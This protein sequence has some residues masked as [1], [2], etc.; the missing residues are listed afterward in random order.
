METGLYQF[1]CAKWRF[2]VNNHLNLNLS[3]TLLFYASRR[4]REHEVLWC[5]FFS[6]WTA[7]WY[8][9]AEQVGQSKN[10]VL[11]IHC[12]NCP[13]QRVTITVG[14]L[15]EL[16]KDGKFLL[17][18]KQLKMV[19]IIQMDVENRIWWIFVVVYFWPQSTVICQISTD[20]KRIQGSLCL[21]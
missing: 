17:Y 12:N 14:P 10:H 3:P 6:F 20:R 13:V 8:L 2:S 4:L 16:V 15:L 11:G 7:V 1:E 21:L 9:F 19:L 18:I 5:I